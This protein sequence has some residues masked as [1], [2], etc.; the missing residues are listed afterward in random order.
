MAPSLEIDTSGNG[1]EEIRENILW[2]LGSSALY[3]RAGLYN[4][5]NSVREILNQWPKLK[6]LFKSPS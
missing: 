1:T 6:T 2:A 5:Q 4:Y 3:I